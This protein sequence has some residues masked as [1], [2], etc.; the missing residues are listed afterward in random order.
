MEPP[1]QARE[2]I[3]RMARIAPRDACDFD[4]GAPIGPF[5]TAVLQDRPTDTSLGASFP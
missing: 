2:L 4:K 1:G 5:G 3:A